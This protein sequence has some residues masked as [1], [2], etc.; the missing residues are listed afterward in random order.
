MSKSKHNGK[1][2]PV[3]PPIVITTDEACRLT[4]ATSSMALF[5]RVAHFIAR[6]TERANVVADDSDLRGAVRMGSQVRY[7]DTIKSGDIR[8]VVLLYPHEPDF[9][10]TARPPPNKE[11]RKDVVPRDFTFEEAAMVVVC[12]TIGLICGFGGLVYLVRFLSL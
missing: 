6:E 8:D 1:T 5:S 11:R 12:V 9:S 2:E 4:L 7:C 3:L 10:L